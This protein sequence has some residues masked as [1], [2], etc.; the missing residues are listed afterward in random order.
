MTEPRYLTDP[1]YLRFTAE[2]LET[3]PLVDQNTAV[4]LPYT[5][6]Y[7][8]GGGQEHDL[9]QIGE[10]RVLD[11]YWG[12]DQRIIHVLDRPLAPGHYEAQIDRQR[13]LSAM[14]HHTGQ[15]LLSAVLLRELNIESISANINTL[16]PSTVDLEV[17]DLPEVDLQR[18][19]DVVKEI[20]FE[21]RPVKSYFLDPAGLAALPLRKPPQVSGTVRIVEI[22]GYDY[23]PCGGTHCLS[24]G[25]IGLL[26]IVRTER[27]NRKLRLH[28]VAGRQALRAFRLIH[29]SAQ[30]A[31]D[32]LS[33]RIE[34]LSSL[35]Q[36]L[37]DQNTRLRLDLETCTAQILE[38]EA[39]R[40]LEQ[41]ETIGQWRSVVHLLSG[42]SPAELR[43]LAGHL[44][45]HS[46]VV[47]VLIA[48]QGQKLSLVVACAPD[49]GI[50]ARDLLNHLLALFGG[51]GGGDSRLAQGGG[52]APENALPG[53]VER[54]KL[55][56]RSMN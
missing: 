41:A 9:G 52:I 37:L 55:W 46:N 44:V 14:Q 32:R 47:A 43:I 19:E 30:Q 40:Y 24:T 5:Y 11:V 39:R 29:R 53:L 27:I 2:V 17:A 25:M 42:R 15:H 18:A 51:R 54:A 38:V 12:D 45:R 23:T 28:F 26:C 35:V 13:R 34:D 8:T 50:D 36:K 22:E 48:Q 31:A 3:F 49:G 16:T 33:T 20:L 1:L 21:D 6:F 4:I 56:I 10:A 7:P